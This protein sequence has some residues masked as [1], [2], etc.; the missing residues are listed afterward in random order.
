MFVEARLDVRSGRPNG[1]AVD[2][3]GEDWVMSSRSCDPVGPCQEVVAVVLVSVGN[4]A[5]LEVDVQ[6]KGR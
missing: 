5:V 1:R 2:Q 3:L 6:S 4:L